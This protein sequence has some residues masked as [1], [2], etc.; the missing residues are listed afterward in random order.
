MSTF[1]VYAERHNDFSGDVV[2][3]PGR[4]VEAENKTDALDEGRRLSGLGRFDSWQF[5][6]NKFSGKIKA[7]PIKPDNDEGTNDT[8]SRGEQA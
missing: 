3:T 1:F 6:A 4:L 7:K 8:K 5:H 2:R